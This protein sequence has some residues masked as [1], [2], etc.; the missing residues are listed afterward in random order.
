MIWGWNGENTGAPY[1]LL[2]LLIRSLE[3]RI[4]VSKQDETDRRDLVET[5]FQI[6]MSDR[7]RNFV[8]SG[9]KVAL[10][11]LKNMVLIGENV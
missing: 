9:Q 2:Y 3:V 6:C 4:V 11:F 5:T 7:R 10:Y 8:T 1:L